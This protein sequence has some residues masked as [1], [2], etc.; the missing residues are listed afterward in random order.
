M[1]DVARFPPFREA[2]SLLQSEYSGYR[3]F[4]VF[5]T[6][7]LLPNSAPDPPNMGGRQAEAR[8]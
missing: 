4:Q 6:Q 1:L 5:V 2:W 3:D 8:K 7:T